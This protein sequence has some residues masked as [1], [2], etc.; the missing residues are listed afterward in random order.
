LLADSVRRLS[1]GQGQRGGTPRPTVLLALRFVG[2]SEGWTAKRD[3]MKLLAQTG[4]DQS[5]S[6][7][8]GDAWSVAMNQ[9]RVTQSPEQ[10]RRLICIG[11][12]K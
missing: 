7:D 5:S 3:P 11:G 12:F 8:A 10:H 1:R 2:P 6:N 4:V 9:T